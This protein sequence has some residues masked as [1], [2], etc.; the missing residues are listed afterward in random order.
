MI[1]LDTIL[2][3]H[4]SDVQYG[5]THLNTQN[6]AYALD[7]LVEAATKQY[8]VFVAGN[9]ASA[10]LSQ[11]WACDHLKGSSTNVYNNHVISLA[12][13]VPLITAI[14]NDIK[15]EEIFTLQLQRH[16]KPDTV[17]VL[18]LI[19]ASGASPNVIHSAQFIRNARPYMHIISLTGFTGQPLAELSDINLH[20]NLHEYET[21]EDI[22]SCIM[23]IMAKA[24]RFRLREL[25]EIE[26]A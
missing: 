21:V 16:T 13:N 14:G 25:S 5:L 23:H 6:L 24:L 22:H 26:K 8:P 12:T 2:T 9:G 10:A 17:G 4:A 1:N 3:K 19:S 20:V 7:L 11:H 18:I 15:F